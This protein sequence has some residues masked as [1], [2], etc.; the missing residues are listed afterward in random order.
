[1][2]Q[3]FCPPEYSSDTA[4]PLAGAVCFACPRS[5]SAQSHLESYCAQLSFVNSFQPHCSAW[6]AASDSACSSH[7]PSSLVPT[8]VDRQHA[9]WGEPPATAPS[10]RARFSLL[11]SSL[12]PT[13]LHQCIKLANL[14]TLSCP[15][16]S[17]PV[18]RIRS[19][20]PT[21]DN[22]TASSVHL[23]MSPEPTGP[24]PLILYLSP[25]TTDY[26]QSIPGLGAA[27]LRWWAAIWVTLPCDGVQMGTSVW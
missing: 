11:A 19:C 18:L 13:W 17:P 20:A 1:M 25:S 10:R 21:V 6:R 16:M 15:V 9:Q 26:H 3:S 4:Q 5:G 14:G 24:K 12:Q 27:E 7:W 22:T 23:S 8:S 2:R